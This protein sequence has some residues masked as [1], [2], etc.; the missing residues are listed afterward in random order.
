MVTDDDGYDDRVMLNVN[1]DDD[2]DG[3]AGGEDDG[4]SVM[5]ML[6]VR[7]TYSMVMAVMR[8]TTVGMRKWW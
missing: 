4:D 5:R 6:R 2:C 3:I 8:M 7:A 1:G